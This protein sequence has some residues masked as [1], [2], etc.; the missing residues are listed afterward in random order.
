MKF[1]PSN[2]VAL[3]GDFNLDLLAQGRNIGEFEQTIYSNNLIPLISI[4]THAK[5]GCNESLIDNIL[6]NSTER[7]LGSGIL[8]SKISHHNPIF[9]FISC[10]IKESQNDTKPKPK[11]DYCESNIESFL[12]DIGRDI[13]QSNFSYDEKGFEKFVETVHEKIELNFKV[14]LL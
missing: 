14:D 1:L 5:P 12:S 3:T 8:E 9:C 6:V 4:A 11:Y 2:N 10:N 7:V 13:Y